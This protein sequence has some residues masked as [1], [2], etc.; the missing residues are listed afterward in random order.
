MASYKVNDVVVVYAKRTAIGTFRGGLSSVKAHDLA[1]NVI[2]D[3]M[4][5]IKVV[6]KEEI[7]EV[8]LGQ[9][10]TAGKV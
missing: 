9:V 6:K 2:K 1:A 4:D 7:S 5:E 3:M 10:L 8:I